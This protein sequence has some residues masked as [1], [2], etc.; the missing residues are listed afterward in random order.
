MGR[1]FEKLSIENVCK[2]ALR[3]AELGRDK[4]SNPLMMVTV[5]IIT[6]IIDNPQ[7]HWGLSILF[8]EE[9]EVFLL[10]R[11]GEAHR[12]GDNCR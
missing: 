2:P 12:A 10:F 11:Y 4:G 7:I 5:K 6:L 3:R 1:D 9:L 8:P